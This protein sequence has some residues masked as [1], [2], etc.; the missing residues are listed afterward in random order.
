MNIQQ[1]RGIVDSL[2]D[3]TIKVV[4]FGSCSRGD[5]THRSDIDLLVV[6][7]GSEEVKGMLKDIHVDGRP[8]SALVMTPSRFFNLKDDDRALY[9]EIR[10]GIILWDGDHH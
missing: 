8:L 2:K 3:H 9:E 5:D 6:A 10:D 1:L 4:L 7:G